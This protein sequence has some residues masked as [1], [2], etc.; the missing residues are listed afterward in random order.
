MP[1]LP[2]V[3]TIRQG[4]EPLIKDKAIASV[5]VSWPR[6]INTELDLSDWQNALV[7]QKIHGLLRRGKY[8]IFQLSN[9]Y[10]ISH[11]RME[12]KYFFYP[13]SE[14]P[15]VKEKHTHVRFIFK[16]HSEL[17]YHDVRK[18]G[19]MELIGLED[20]SS[21]FRFKKLG[22]EPTTE[23]FKINIFAEKLS[24]IKKSI[25]PAL[26]DQHLVAGLGNIYVDEVLFQAKIH[27]LT[28]SQQ[29]T[30][31]Q[32]KQLHHAII[33]VLSRASEEGGS[34]IRTY[35]NAYG[36]EGTFQQYHQV[37][38]KENQPCPICGTSIEK[39]SVGQRG[40]HFCP[41]CQIFEEK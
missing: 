6:I 3:E 41:N 18:F 35:R 10:L 11:L 31:S 24:R 4:L 36:K 22:P 40:T 33:D 26:I 28:S 9:F 14:V 20:L 38:G 19:R 29:L 1:E 37:Y 32:I 21:Y 17:H 5:D 12:G 8:L 13:A 34:S 25:K 7:G 2:E 30:S 16:D 27:P 23:S 39:I 15:L